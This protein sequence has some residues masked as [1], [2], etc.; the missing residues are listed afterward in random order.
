MDDEWIIIKGMDDEKKEKEGLSFH[1]LI[2][3]PA[4]QRQVKWLH[5]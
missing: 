1:A 5:V 4:N 2:R 3:L